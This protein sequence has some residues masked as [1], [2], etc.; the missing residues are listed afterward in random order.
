MNCINNNNNNYNNNKIMIPDLKN[1]NIGSSA[2]DGRS[3]GVADYQVYGFYTSCS[4][5]VYFM[6]EELNI[7]YQTCLVNIR[8]GE[9]FKG[10]FAE[11]SPNNK[12]PMLIDNTYS[13]DNDDDYQ[14]EP[15][16]KIFESGAILLYLAEKYQKFL[17]PLSKPKER[18]Q[19][20]QW[21]SWQ[22]S[23]M[24]PTLTSYVYYFMMAP[25]PV[26]F[27]M[28][29]ADQDLHKILKVLDKR[30]DDGRKYIC[31]EFSIA[32]IACFGFGSYFHLNVFKGWNK[33]ENVVR[34]VNTM[35]SRPSISKLLPI[36]E[37]TL[38][39]RK[40]K[41]LDNQELVL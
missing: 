30:L 3:E 39:V 28:E 17:P 7:P 18:C 13:V 20:Q 32:D 6:F 15:P 34:W 26:A 9:H 24:Q 8:S 40:L 33:Y 22:I 2:D 25:E 31:N 12:I 21:L 14:D 29:K 38:R 41:R 37:Q 23:E 1:N 10:D 27:G 36:V 5:K 16:L 35:S 4:F 19:V 11:M